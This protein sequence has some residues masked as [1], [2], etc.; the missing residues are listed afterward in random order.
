[1]ATKPTVRIGHLRITDHLILGIT[2]FKLLK[3]AEA[4]QYSNIETIPMIGWDYLGD[5][6]KDGNLDG[7][8]MLAPYAMELF[9]SAA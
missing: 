5:A 1:M 9:H 2:K 8:F 7:A 4:F 6:L 3:E